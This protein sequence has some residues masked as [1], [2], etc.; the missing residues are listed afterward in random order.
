MLD[1]QYCHKVNEADECFQECGE[2]GKPSYI[3]RSLDLGVSLEL[4]VK[5][6]VLVLVSS[7]KCHIQNSVLRNCFITGT[8]EMW[9]GVGFCI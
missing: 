7:R 1:T 5:I 2:E 6:L 4:L 8:E 9:D 3:F